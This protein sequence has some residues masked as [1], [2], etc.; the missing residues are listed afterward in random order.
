MMTTGTDMRRVIDIITGMLNRVREL[1]EETE[2]NILFVVQYKD[3]FG[4][5]THS[6]GI[7]DLNALA[8]AVGRLYRGEDDL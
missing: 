1:P 5:N 8:D 7:G 6:A 2:V 3:E 4:P